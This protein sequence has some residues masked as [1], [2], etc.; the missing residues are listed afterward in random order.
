MKITQQMLNGEMPVTEEELKFLAKN[1]E[2]YNLTRLDV[3]QVTDFSG[4][5]TYQE[6]FNQDIGN[7]NVSNG[8]NFSGMFSHAES[9][10][11]PIGNWNVSNGT[12]FSWMFAFTSSFN[13]P[14][15]DWNVSSGIDFSYMFSFTKSFNQPLG[16][17]DVSNGINFSTMFDYS[18]A[19]NQIIISNWNLSKEHLTQLI[20]TNFKL[21]LQ[22]SFEKIGIV[23]DPLQLQLVFKDSP[24][25]PFYDDFNYRAKELTLIKTGC[26]HGFIDEEKK[27]YEINTNKISIEELIDICDIKTTKGIA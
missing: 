10:N 14:I 26:F 24:E 21:S 19:F 9:F 23:S 13:Q 2:T 15:G 8:T 3:S 20:E 11:Q 17:W 7:W 6:L 25:S 27:A 4:L 5:F 22:H 1:H 16:N 12:N 18:L